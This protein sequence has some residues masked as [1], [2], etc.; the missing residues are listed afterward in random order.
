MSRLRN[1]TNRAVLACAGAALLAA[2]AVLGSA[3][4]VVRDRLPSDWPRLGSGRAWLDGDALG[5]WRDQDWWPPLVMSALAVGVLLS[6]CWGVA[7]VR[8]GRLRELPLGQP[9]VTLSG[10]ALAAAVAERAQGLDGVARAHVSLLG[11]PRR[12]RAR[13][14]LV[15]TAEGRPEAVLGELV[16]RTVAEARA[17]AAPR[18]LTVEVR[19]TGRHH[20]ARRLR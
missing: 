10:P 2:G 8:A 14:T 16:R 3:T 20:R 6:L 5:R 15:L 19:L 9:E 7:Q 1:G 17:A 11:R 13:V 12:L 18:P 4:D